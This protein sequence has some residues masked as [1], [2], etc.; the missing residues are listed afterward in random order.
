MS[1]CVSS[2]NMPKLVGDLVK[3]FSFELKMRERKERYESR[4]K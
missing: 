1:L 3:N 4:Y 2:A